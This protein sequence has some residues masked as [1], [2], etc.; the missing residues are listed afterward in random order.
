MKPICFLSNFFSGSLLF[1]LG[2]HSFAV[3]IATALK[4]FVMYT[5]Y[6][7][8]THTQTQLKVESADLT[9]KLSLWLQINSECKQ[10]ENKTFDEVTS[11]RFYLLF[12]C[13]K[14]VM[15]EMNVRRFLYF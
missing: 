1:W 8:H 11:A 10:S 13:I 4:S 9:D 2:F 15:Y 7:T 3:S 12:F 6:S 14:S 5:Q